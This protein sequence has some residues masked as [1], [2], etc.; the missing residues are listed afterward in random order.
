MSV[1]YAAMFT[2]KEFRTHLDQ[3]SYSISAAFT[4]GETPAVILTVLFAVLTVGFCIA[5]HKTVILCVGNMPGLEYRKQ[6]Y[7]ERLYNATLVIPIVFVSFTVNILYIYA[8]ENYTD[9]ELYLNSS[10]VIFNFLWLE[11]LV[12]KILYNLLQ[13]GNHVNTA[14]Y[15]LFILL[16]GDVVIPILATSG[17]SSLCFHDIFW[18]PSFLSTVSSVTICSLYFVELPPIVTDYLNIDECYT[19]NTVS[20]I[21]ELNLPFLYRY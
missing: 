16:M 15:Y 7:S 10:I 18:P 9:L 21:I 2:E 12:P 17:A 4:Y 3:Y 11:L 13:N 1:V 5:L 14:Q 8:K 6:S 19:Y 20:E